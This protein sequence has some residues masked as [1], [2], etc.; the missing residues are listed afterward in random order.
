MTEINSNKFKFDTENEKCWYY[1]GKKEV[2]VDDSQKGHGRFSYQ[3]VFNLDKKYADH[4]I[5]YKLIYSG[6]KVYLESWYKKRIEASK[7]KDEVRWVHYKKRVEKQDVIMLIE[8]DYTDEMIMVYDKIK[9]KDR[10]VNRLS[11]EKQ[12]QAKQ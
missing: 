2:Q 7:K 1:I 11:W 10:Y 5:N 4:W 3:V 8:F 6:G 9:Q 12:G